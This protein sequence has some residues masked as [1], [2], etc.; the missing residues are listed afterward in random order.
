VTKETSRRL[1]PKR[2]SLTTVPSRAGPKVG[3]EEVVRA[4]ASAGTMATT[5]S[6]TA[7]ARN[8]AFIAFRTAA[9]PVL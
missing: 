4:G 6:R 2:S 8:L 3:E 5:V 9:L 7:R 1:W